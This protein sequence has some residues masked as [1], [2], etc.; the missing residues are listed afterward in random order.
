MMKKGKIFNIQHFSVNDGPGIRTVVF[1]KGCPLNCVW[2]HNPE[3]KSAECE[4]YFFEN[5]CIKCG[6]CAGVCENGVHIF[7]KE[8]HYIERN[9]CN[10]CG[11]CAEHCVTSAIEI[12]GKEYSVD[13]VMMDVEKDD[14]FFGKDGGVTFSGGEPFYQFDFLYELLKTCKKKGYSVCIETSGAVQTD[15][16]VKAAMFT[17]YFLY[18]FKESSAEIHKK[19]TGA[20][21]KLIMKNLSVLNEINAPVILRCPVIPGINDR[22]EHFV[23]I[24]EIANRFDNILRVELEPYHSLG[25]R[26]NTYLGKKEYKFSEADENMKNKWI[27]NVQKFTPK[28]VKFA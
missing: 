1:F 27:E 10:F 4:L 9:K 21:N 7:E 28:P 2:C 6:K 8:N 20:D 5:N 14:L 18:D 13:E 22:Q 23:K 3:S 16:I 11:K 19:Y 24:A 26:K 25:E 15:K 17:D 12:I